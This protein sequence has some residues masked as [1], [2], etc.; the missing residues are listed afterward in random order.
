MLYDLNA[1]YVKKQLTNAFLCLNLFLIS[2][3]LNKSLMKLFLKIIFIVYFPDKYITQKM[4]DEAV[5]ESLA[6][7]KLIPDWFVTSKMIKKL[8]I[9]LYAD[10]NM[11][12]FDEDSG[13]IVFNCYRM[14]ILN[15]DLNNI[16]LDDN[17]DEDDLDTITLIRLLAY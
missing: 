10:E 8:F 14:G 3:K 15:I 1:L 7:L 12:Y 6:T 13:N 4:Y 5:N 9:A 16:D 17:F 2:I 11:F